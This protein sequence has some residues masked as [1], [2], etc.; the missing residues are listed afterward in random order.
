MTASFVLGI[1]PGKTFF[2]ATLMNSTREK[3]W[4]GREFAMSRD[5]FEQ[6]KSSLPAGDVTIGVE[7]SGRI[8]DN[9]M[10]WLSKWKAS[11]RDRNITL[12]RVNPGQSARFGGPKPRRDQTDGSD[13]DHIAEF[14]RVYQR[15]LDAFN[16]DAQ[17]EAMVRVVNE[18]R[19]LVEQLAGIKCR[20]QE[21][22]MVC[23]PEFTRIFPDPLTKLAR[24]V[25]RETPTARVAARR[26]PLSLARLKSER[27]G[28]SL[29]IEK[30]RQLVQFA[31]HSIASACEDHDAGALVF[32]IDQLELLEKRIDAIVQNLTRYAQQ[33]KSET[34]A[35]GGVSPA[36]QIQLLDTI[37]GI[38][39]V[40]ASTLVLGTRGLTRFSAGKALS[41]QWASCP[42][43]KKTGTS[44]DQTSMTTRGDHK[45]RAMLYLVTQSACTSDP[46]FAFHKW[47]MIQHGL[48]PQQAVCAVMNKM[49]RVI[50]AVAARNEVYDVNRMLNQIRIH[51][52]RLWKTFVLLHKDDPKIWKKVNVEYRKIA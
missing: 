6:L 14:T 38:A 40:A 10:A 27:G 47:R 33:A 3:L 4:K 37:P 49:S 1:D 13:S 26:K 21:Q 43:R 28:R 51:H 23:F 32:L 48:C 2:A 44:L 7:A 34:P 30:A 12:I 29:G 41:A 8:D 50:W 16:C 31:T 45:N 52:A 5:G 11:C 22:V 19:H 20:L 35:E 39:L 18:R 17:A 46:A 24:A 25:L 42:H 15:E 36:R 9:L